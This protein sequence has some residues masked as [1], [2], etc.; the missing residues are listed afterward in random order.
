MHTLRTHS[1][2]KSIPLDTNFQKDIAWFTRF[3]DK[4]N[5]ST[6]FQKE[7]FE[8]EVFLDASLS[9]IAGVCGTDTYHHGIPS[10]LKD[11]PIVVLEMFNILVATRLWALTYPF[12]D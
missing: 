2:R 11:H 7:S 5:G 3:I 10:H 1:A 12:A 6:I 8:F 9:G 4:Y